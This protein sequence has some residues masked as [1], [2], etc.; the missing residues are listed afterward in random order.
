MILTCPQC[1]TRFQADEAE[2][3]PAGRT[4][5]CGK[6]RHHWHQPGFAVAPEP[7]TVPR[8]AILSQGEIAGAIP[9]AAAL[10]RAPAGFAPE[11]TQLR[12]MEARQPKPFRLAHIALA[13]GWVALIT[14]LLLVALL[15]NHYREDIAMIWSHSGF[16]QPSASHQIE[17]QGIELRNVGYRREIDDGQ[18]MLVIT[19][20][21]ANSADHDMPVPKTIRVS[22]SDENNNELFQA[23][24]PANMA[25]L[26]AGQSVTF[27]TRIHD[28][29]ST[30]L[31]LQMHLEN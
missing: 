15:V 6:C 28:L 2:F 1:A 21:I 7:A 16:L 17:M 29:P 3:P 20:T 9:S 31:H 23:A 10:P 25:T 24:I 22:L 27:H 13:A 19:G 12:T 5:R 18:S 30:N 8:P 14:T 11:R 4:V 26:G